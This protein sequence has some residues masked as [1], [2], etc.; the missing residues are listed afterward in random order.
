M[1]GIF[2]RASDYWVPLIGLFTGARE[3]EICQLH[4]SDILQD[5][6][7][8]LWVFHFNADDDKKQKTHG[9]ERKVP[10]H[11]VLKKLGLLAYL[12]KITT[13]KGT[14]LFPDEQRNQR[15]E[16]SGFSKRF[17]RHK[18]EC[19]IQT[20]PTKRKDFHSFR[21]NL[22]EQLAG[23]GCP[24][25]VIN[26]ITG[27][28]QA[29]QSHAIKTYSDGPTLETAAKWLERLD[30]GIDFSKLRPNGWKKKLSGKR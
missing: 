9:S 8:G 20:K 7:T 5:E 28:S 15:G 10:V 12:D 25:Y 6:E 11:P 14:R 19:G 3:A 30:F 23:K 29:R 17:N 27:H 24:D 21:H 16:F 22:S 13:S 2:Q 1:K 18:V 26:A 4:T